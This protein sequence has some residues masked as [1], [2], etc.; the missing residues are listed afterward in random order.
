MPP[1]KSNRSRA[2][3]WRIATRLAVSL[4][5]AAGFVYALQRG[6][7]PFVPAG[8]MSG[9]STWSIVVCVLLLSFCSYLRAK[10]WF[11]M[12][13]PLAPQLRSGR[14]IGIGLV[15]IAAIFFGPLRL[16]EMV[17][18]Y[19]LSQEGEVPFVPA[20]GTVAAERIIDGV[21]MVAFTALALAASTPLAPLPSRVGG[22]PIPV[23]LVPGAIVASSVMFGVAFALM[24]IFYIARDTARRIVRKVVGVVSLRLADYCAGVVE[25]LAESLAFLPS[26]QRLAPFLRETLLYWGLMGMTQYSLL[27]GV[28]LRP[29]VAQAFVTLGISSL[30]SLLPAGPGFFGAYQVS[31][32]TSLAM[33]YAEPDV[34]TKGAAF[35]FL[36]YV[37]VV[38]VTA[39]GGLIG[40]LMLARLPPANREAAES[41]TVG[42][43]SA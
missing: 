9:V 37:C 43:S 23:T 1:P 27:H 24:I 26:W 35:V 10:R 40:L 28:G 14:V 41:E 12:L 20:M 4:L 30:G 19:M 17:R 33:Y 34:L 16:G 39:A 38:G 5:I 25:R 31:A 13:L 32:Y 7:L 36:S 29:T 42:S 21:I 18:P 3:F 22:L 8:V 2:P 6:G 11:Y 15:G